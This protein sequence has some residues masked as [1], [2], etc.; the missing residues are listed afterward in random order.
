M[1][2]CR[3]MGPALKPFRFL[4]QNSQFFPVLTS[5]VQAQFRSTLMILQQAHKVEVTHYVWFSQTKKIWGRSIAGGHSS[6]QQGV[7]ELL[8][9]VNPPSPLGNFK[10]FI[11][12]HQIFVPCYITIS[13][14][15]PLKFSQFLLN[16]FLNKLKTSLKNVLISVFFENL[17]SIQKICYE[18]SKI[19]VLH[20]S[21]I[22]HA[23]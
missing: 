3:L 17:C 22:L 15:F 16:K 19:N 9:M 4:Q 21:V 6:A 7:I 11:S 20:S 5:V 23:R 1:Q 2:F 13:G 12:P 14:N 18:Y 8:T 10:M